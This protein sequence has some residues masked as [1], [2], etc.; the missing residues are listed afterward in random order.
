MSTKGKKKVPASA[1]PLSADTI[2]TSPADLK[3]Q[4]TEGIPAEFLEEY[5]KSVFGFVE[6]FRKSSALADEGGLDSGRIEELMGKLARA[7]NKVNLKLLQNELGKLDQQPLVVKKK[8]E[9]LSRGEKIKVYRRAT[10]KLVTAYGPI[11]FTRL[12]MIRSRGRAERDRAP[13]TSWDMIFPLDETLGIHKLP[14]K[15]TIGAMLEIGRRAAM[16]FSYESARDT[17]ERECCINTTGVTVR[18]VANRLGA[19][20]LAEDLELGERAM[21]ELL[22]FKNLSSALPSVTDAKEAGRPGR[23]RKPLEDGYDPDKLEVHEDELCI[24]F[25][26]TPIALRGTRSGPAVPDKVHYAVVFTPKPSA[27]NPN[28]GRCEFVPY[29]GFIEP[30]KSLVLAAAF[31]AGLN[32]APGTVIVSDGSAWAKPLRDELFP[33]SR[34]LIDIGLVE[35]ELREFATVAGL[36]VTPGSEAEQKIAEITALVMKGL[37]TEAF[38]E[39]RKLAPG[40]RPRGRHRLMKLLKGPGPFGGPPGGYYREGFS[41]AVG[42]SERS[43]RTFLETR[44]R[45]SGMRWN[46]GHGQHVLCLA[47]KEI[48]GLWETD[49]VSRVKGAFGPSPETGNELPTANKM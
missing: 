11:S 22:S 7:Q 32:E 36:D 23:A 18:A 12:S 30:F 29:I 4:S 10:R 14:F 20:V 49:V 41:R 48:S 16:T 34:L 38:V 8:S 6:D 15:M 47:A 24:A 43:Q 26:E 37:S 1:V 13:W 19:L 3:G 25:S 46:L 28:A 33:G 42:T 44:L 35:K 45:R 17:L 40:T 21:E 39:T 27:G 2:A 31:R 5:R 9:A